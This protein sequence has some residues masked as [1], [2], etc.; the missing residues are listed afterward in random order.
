MELV[1]RDSCADLHYG[2]GLGLELISTEHGIKFE[3]N[4]NSKDCF[5]CLCGVSL[6]GCGSR[7]RS[8]GRLG[9]DFLNCSRL[10]A[11]IDDMMA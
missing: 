8:S 6:V 4:L 11:V 7:T 5:T 10:L 2:Y 3:R 9:R 1:A